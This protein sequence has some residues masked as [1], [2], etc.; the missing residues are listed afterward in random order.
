MAP[1]TRSSYR[2]R[3]P[4][5]SKAVEGLQIAAVLRALPEPPLETRGWRFPAEDTAVLAL[6]GDADLVLRYRPPAPALALERG[7]GGGA[8]RTPFQHQLAARA[9][10]PLTSV[11]QLKLDRV[12][13]LEFGGEEGFVDVPPVRLVFELTGRNANLI[14]T[15][16]EG[17]ILGL[18]RPVSAEQNRYRQLAVGAVW[19]PP[20]PY[21]KLD[22]RTLTERELNVLVGQPL[23]NALVRHVDGLGPRL[24]TE[25]ARRAGLEP[26][27]PVQVGDLP[28]VLRALASLVDDPSP[29]AASEPPTWREETEASLRKPLLA[30]LARRRR[31]LERRLEDHTRAR[32]ELAKAERWQRFGDLLLAHAH[33]LPKGAREVTLEDWETGEP[34]KIALD[35]ALSPS[36]NAERYYRRA[37]RARARAERAEREIPRIKREREALDAEIAR[38]E[39]MPLAELRK[40]RSRAERSS[41]AVGLR[42]EAPGGF[43]VWVGRN[44][45]ENDWLT[46]SAHSGDVWMH[47]QGVPGSHVIVRARGKPVPLETLLFAAQLAAYHSRAR[48]EKNVPVDYTLKKHVWRPKGA[49]PGEVLYTQ[50][51]TLFVDAEAPDS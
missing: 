24:A 18:D 37:K 31:T 35:P 23:A 14:L 3:S 50:A 17:R 2:W 32:A 27:Q 34:V 26:K 29:A 51:K 12:V 15:D 6:A 36:E 9:R 22:P 30:A 45:K 5:Y 43:E 48:G 4:L 19:T 38:V 42:L 21:E 8:P 16:L 39:Q 1:F 46:R 11:R 47:A 44:R 10:G 41:Q 7:A 13:V 33:A 40:L 20:P 28:K 25:A 49:A